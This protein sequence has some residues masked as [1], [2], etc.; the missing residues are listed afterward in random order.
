MSLCHI[1]IFFN[2]IVIISSILTLTE[3]FIDTA[4][5]AVF[6][7]FPHP[8]FSKDLATAVAALLINKGAGGKSRNIYH[9]M[10]PMLPDS[11]P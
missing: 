9:V 3:L 10:G 2:S 6:S 8:S 5:P 7:H 4:V 1:W 11:K